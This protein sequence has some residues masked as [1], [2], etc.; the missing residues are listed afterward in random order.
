MKPGVLK[1]VMG[2]RQV[3]A[4]LG[5]DCSGRL[6]YEHAYGRAQEEAWQLVILCWF[7]HLGKGLCK[8][9]N[10]WLALNQA[11]DKDL[12]AYPKSASAWLQE[13]RYLNSLYDNQGS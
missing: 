10:R 4:R 6:T 12:N 8:D 1:E 3:C 11:T 7:H 9:K 2:R 5:T 13:K